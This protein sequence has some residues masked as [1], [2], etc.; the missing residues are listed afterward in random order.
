MPCIRSK[1]RRQGGYSFEI[2]LRRT[3][4]DLWC[5]TY[6]ALQYGGSLLVDVYRHVLS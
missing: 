6:L 5:C 2:P 1:Q 3:R 4:A